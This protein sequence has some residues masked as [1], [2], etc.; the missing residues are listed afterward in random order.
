MSRVDLMDARWRTS[1]F[2]GAGSEANCVQVARVDDLAGLRDSKNPHGPVVLVGV[3]GWE[4][5]RGFLR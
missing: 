4:A 3:A 5:L 1:S 2:S